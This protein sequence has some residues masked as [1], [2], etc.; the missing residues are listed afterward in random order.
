MNF[1]SIKC[2]NFTH[3]SNIKIK[4]ETDGKIN[5]Y[6]YCVNCGFKTFKTIDKKKELSDY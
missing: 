5:L 3:K 4:R 6:S 2:S 1:Y